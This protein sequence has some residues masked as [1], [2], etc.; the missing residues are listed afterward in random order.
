M[1]LAGSPILPRTWSHHLIR[2]DADLGLLE[3]LVNGQLEAL[4][5][6]TSLGKEGG[7]VF[8]PVIGD[9]GRLS[10]GA[11]FSGMMD[12]IR[13]YNCY[14]ETPSLSKYPL[15]GGRVESRTLDLGSVNSQILKLE[16]FGG[17]TS[18]AAGGFKN[19]YAGNGCLS[20]KDHSELNFFVRTNNS[21]YRWNDVP[22]IPVKPGVAL[23]DTFRGR[24]IQIAVDFYPSGDGE[25]SP[26]LSELRVIYNAAE[27]PPPPTQVIAVAWDGAVTLSWK[28]SVSRDV[29]GY[30]IYYGTAQGEYF[31]AIQGNTVHSSPID[32]GN[33]TSLRIEG[34]TNGTL[35]YFAVAAYYKP[36]PMVFESVRQVLEPGRQVQ[37]PGDFSRE[38][39]ARPL[40]RPEGLSGGGCLNESY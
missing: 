2:Y 23:S 27:P 5:Y 10:F 25:T 9:N 22:W 28:A 24:F 6:T 31:G 30:L 11:N 16:A 17:R 37:E 8:T 12:E 15:K 7:D 39:A 36:A 33:R 40:Q 14:L 32:A 34:L 4:D 3:Y 35:Y 21:I 20:F 18:S 13:I 19:E 38:V 26:Y 29:G 1:V